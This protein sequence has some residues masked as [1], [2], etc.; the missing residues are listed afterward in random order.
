MAEQ[1]D[2]R[3]F[4]GGVHEGGDEKGGVAEDGIVPR[5]MVDE[6][7]DPP[8]ER[9]DDEQALPADSLGDVTDRSDPSQD[10]IDPSGGDQAD[11]T[12]HGGTGG[13][14]G[15]VKEQMKEGE[16][17]PWPQ[18]ANVARETTDEDENAQA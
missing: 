7:G 18:A 8:P 1:Q 16:P 17:V 5:D 2:P 9:S 15:E 4:R 10:N 11:A 13:N 14:V 3:T 6:P 12:S